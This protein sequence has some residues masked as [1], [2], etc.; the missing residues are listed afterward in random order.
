MVSYESKCGCCDC[1]L[2]VCS[3][4]IVALESISLVKLVQEST[5]TSSLF[6][7]LASMSHT[8]I[9]LNQLAIFCLLF[10]MNI[11][12]Q[13]SYFEGSDYVCICVSSLQSIYNVCLIFL[14]PFNSYL[15]N[16]STIPFEDSQFLHLCVCVCSQKLGGSRVP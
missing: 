16:T 5:T 6:I 10:P 13:Y 2:V 15:H 1:L 7:S 3:D 11:S 9:T 8:H 14:F 4:A 12:P